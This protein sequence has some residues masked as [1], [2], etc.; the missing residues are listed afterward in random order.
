[1]IAYFGLVTN[2]KDN[3]LPQDSVHLIR[4]VHSEFAREKN[5]S[6]NTVPI[7]DVL[8]FYYFYPL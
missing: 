1:M 7:T 5:Y 2:C 4:D 6:D 3:C 8:Y